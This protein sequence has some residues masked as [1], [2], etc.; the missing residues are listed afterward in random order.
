MFAE[1]AADD[2]KLRA[3]QQLAIDAFRRKRDIFT[4][5]VLAM[6]V[7]YPAA[8]FA[9][10]KLTKSST[11]TVIAAVAGLLVWVGVIVGGFVS[12]AVICPHC[13]EILYHQ[14]G[15]YCQHCGGKLR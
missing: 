14:Q 5:A 15:P 2:R 4:A 13:G 10:S 6:L 3:A 11:A 7:L 8:V 9:V 1:Q 12:G